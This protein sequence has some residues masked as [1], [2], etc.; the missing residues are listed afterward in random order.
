MQ[1]VEAVGSWMCTVNY[2]GLTSVCELEANTG[3]VAEVMGPPLAHAM[4]ETVNL[5]LRHPVGGR[6]T[7]AETV[8]L[9]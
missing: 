6:M 9:D 7:P 1:P 4:R 8:E 3:F 2:E 5:A